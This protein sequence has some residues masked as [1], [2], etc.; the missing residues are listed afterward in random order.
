M[1]AKRSWP[2]HE[3]DIVA[4][5]YPTEGAEGCLKH[6][7]ADRTISS[8]ENKARRMRTLMRDEIKAR[9]NSEGQIRHHARAANVEEEAQSGDCTE[10]LQACS[11]FQVGYRVAVM[12]GTLTQY[13]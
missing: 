5:I 9:R 13:Q 1:T 3:E 8:V 12:T 2:P 4:R 7:P 6:L 11:I 10:Y